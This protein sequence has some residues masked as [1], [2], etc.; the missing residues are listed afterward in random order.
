MHR[1]LFS[2]VQSQ[3][4]TKVFNETLMYILSSYSPQLQEGVLV[5]EVF[6][7]L[8]AGADW[9]AGRHVYRLKP[10]PT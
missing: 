8:V 3:S 6:G 7:D 1:E 5:V 10:S 9:V 2:L 4:V